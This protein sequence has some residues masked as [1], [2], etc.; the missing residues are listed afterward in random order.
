MKWV[1]KLVKCFFFGQ[2]AGNK[3]AGVACCIKNLVLI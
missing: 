1:F 2:I 3:R